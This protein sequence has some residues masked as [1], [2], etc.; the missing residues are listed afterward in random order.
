MIHKAGYVVTNDNTTGIVAATALASPLWL[1]RAKDAAGSVSSF[2]EW[3]L[4][5]LGAL[6]LLVQIIRKVQEILNERARRRA[7]GEEAASTEE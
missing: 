1:D 6:W 7:A 4:P 2:A 5:V 3:S